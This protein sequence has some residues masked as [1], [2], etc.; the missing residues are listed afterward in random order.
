LVLT[1]KGV[2]SKEKKGVTSAF[3]TSRREKEKR[4]ERDNS[5]QSSVPSRG[6][7]EGRKTKSPP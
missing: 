5:L 3:S 7:G 2:V 1:G 6:A 4:E